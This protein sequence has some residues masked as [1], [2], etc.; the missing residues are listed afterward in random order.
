[1]QKINSLVISLPQSKLT[2]SYSQNIFKLWWTVNTFRKNTKVPFI[3][4]LLIDFYY[5]ISFFFS[6]SFPT[7]SRKHLLHI[8]VTKTRT[9]KNYTPINTKLLL[10]S[11][12]ILNLLADLPNDTYFSAHQIDYLRHTSFN[13]LSDIWHTKH[14]HSLARG[15]WSNP[16]YK[17]IL[18][19]IWKK[20]KCPKIKAKVSIFGLVHLNV[21]LDFR[22]FFEFSG[23][24]WKNGFRFCIFCRCMTK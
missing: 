8:F 7:N 2:I 13:R 20:Q 3:Q 12:K 21:K 5:F 18:Q 23:Q 9:N 11:D 24:K 22:F 19:S 4:T 1:M 16:L 14:K 15:P 6:Q 10:K 17:H